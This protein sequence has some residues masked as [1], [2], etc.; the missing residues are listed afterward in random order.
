M[1]RRTLLG[2][3]S[4]GVVISLVGCLGS[5]NRDSGGTGGETESGDPG[6]SPVADLELTA[7][8][9][10]DFSKRVTYDISVEHRTAERELAASVIDNDSKAINATNRPFPEN[11]PFVY[12]ESVY[13]LSY[14]VTDSATATIFRLTLSEVDN[15]EENNNTI[16]YTA[17]PRVDK[18]A[19]KEY[20]WGDGGPF[21]ADGVEVVYHDTE[22]SNSTLVPEPERSV[23]TWDSE[24]R[25]R[26][27]VE[28][29]SDT[30]VNTYEYTA[31]RIHES[32]DEFG[33]TVRE[34]HEFTLADLSDNQ[35]EIVSEAKES[36]NGYEIRDGEPSQAFEGLAGRFG[37][38]EKVTRV[39]RADGDDSTPSGSY[40]VRHD[41]EIY[42]AELSIAEK[43][44]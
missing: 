6:T 8:S 9:D 12:N 42:W 11:R 31:N 25:A 21:Q 40:I 43:N 35:G 4:S 2:S 34:N 18:E 38:E 33:S 27:V 44:D 3:V 5:S 24:T 1:D 30:D 7:V 29:S 16:E 14:D 13:E 36:T 41:D 39:Y 28:E 22:I 32:A 23:I 37:R 10:V 26:I 17:L 20:G 15:T 19:L